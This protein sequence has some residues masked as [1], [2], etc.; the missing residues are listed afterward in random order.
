MIAVDTSELAAA[1]ARYNVERLGL[2]SRVQVLLGSWCEPVQ[3]LVGTCAGV[4]SNPPY[5]TSAE[6]ST[7]Q[8]EVLP[9]RAARSHVPTCAP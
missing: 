1:W 3:H 5:I 9:R 8:T 2:Q 4:L 7:L 6:L